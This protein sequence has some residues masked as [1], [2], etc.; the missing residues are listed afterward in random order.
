MKRI[1]VIGMIAM[2]L[3]LG[4]F[5]GQRTDEQDEYFYKINALIKDQDF[6]TAKI[7]DGKISLYDEGQ[8]V[9]EISFGEYDPKKQLEYIR[10]DGPVIYFV[11]AGSL[12]DECG[13]IFINDETN[14]IFDGIKTLTRT[15]GNSYCYKTYN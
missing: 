6:T 15:G 7:D 9:K 3:C 13:I 1:I 14:N 8:I 4:L 11:T 12:D 10:K 2:A 5:I